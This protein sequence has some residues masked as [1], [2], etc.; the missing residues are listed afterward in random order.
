MSRPD[1]VLSEE[2][3][4]KF[5]EM[6]SKL[7]QRIAADSKQFKELER[8]SQYQPFVEAIRLAKEKKITKP[9]IVPNTS[10]WYFET[11]LQGWMRHEGTGMLSSFLLAIKGFPYEEMRVDNQQTDK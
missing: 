6:A 10:Y 4:T 11:D 5:M 8:F 1:K 2:E 7:E 3:K 9:L